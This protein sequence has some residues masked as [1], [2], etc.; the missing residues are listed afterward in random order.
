MLPEFDLLMP[1]TLSEA[2]EMLADGVPDV[3]PL[4]GGT[5]LIPDMR[6]GQLSPSAVV[7]VGGLEELRGIRQENGHL[8]VGGGTTVAELREDPLIAQHAPILMEAAASFG[9]P[10][11]RN[12]ATVGGNLVN[13]APCADTAPPLLALNAEIELASKERV[14]RVPLED[15]LVDAYQ[16]ACQPH[17]LLVA[18][19]WPVSPPHSAGAF[20]KLGLRKISCMAKIDVAVVVEGDEDGRCREARIALG[21]VAPR[22]FRVHDAEA[23]L[24]DQSLTPEI[25]AEAARLA[26]EAARPRVG[27][28]YKRQVVEAL[29]RRLLTRS[30]GSIRQ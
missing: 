20:R 29:T 30:A 15:F 7:N 1:K 13:A 22:H 23:L 16:T 8:V 26:A 25:I 17:E 10:L 5:N 19:R 21:A 9:N 24:R 28:E 11:I 2:L 14:R 6:G 12:R 18:V 3:V 27:S 4:A